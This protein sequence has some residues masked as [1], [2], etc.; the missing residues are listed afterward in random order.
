M[1]LFRTEVVTPSK[2]PELGEVIIA[3][4]TKYTSIF[5]VILFITLISA[6]FIS[7][8]SFTHKHTVTG[9]IAAL[10]GE[11]RFTAPGDLIVADVF[12]TANDLVAAGTPLLKLVRK[13]HT[14]QE[15]ETNNA[16]MAQLEVQSALI[17]RQQ[18]ALSNHL[19]TQQYTLSLRQKILTNHSVRLSE[20]V[21]LAKRR[22]KITEL[23]NIKFVQLAKQGLVSQL[24]ADQYQ[25]KLIDNQLQ[26]NEL[27]QR[28]ESLDLQIIETDNE[29][30][31]ITA[32]TERNKNE[33]ARQLSQLQN[34][35]T[36]LTATQEV[37]LVAEHTSVVSVINIKL[38]QHVTQGQ[39][40]IG[41]TPPDPV[42]YAELL[43]PSRAI[44]FIEP[45]TT[46]NLKLNAFPFEK[47]GHVAA[48]I[49]Q[50][51]RSAFIPNKDH[52]AQDTIFQVKARLSEQSITAY[53]EPR[54]FQ[55]GMTLSA[56]LHVD[57]RTLAEWLFD[58]LIA[59]L[60][61]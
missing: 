35:I 12:V 5:V 4:P 41:L 48:E 44:S 31:A 3:Q 23:Q 11:T 47:F 46:A 61:K 49:T 52:Q 1:G 58:P 16:T 26:L 14:S 54:H 32:E 9:Q 56:D 15:L 22:N 57:N 55:S 19:K 37:V 13:H 20:Q 39:F 42:F 27:N 7:S 24:Q 33:L 2:S 34:Q 30:L 18:L 50:I 38:G 43:V 59:A 6:A 10:E 28:L 51:S 8:A 60:G 45:G 40:L 17:Q 25:E 53:G 21:Q 29:L 36:Q